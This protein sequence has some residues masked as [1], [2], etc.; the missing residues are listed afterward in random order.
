ME[1]PTAKTTDTKMLLPQLLSKHESKILLDWI[2]SLSRD[3]SSSR[4]NV[5]EDDLKR[6]A[7]EFLSALR[8]A[9][10]Q[11]GGADLQAAPWERT[12]AVLADISR[13]QADQGA[14]P[15]EV[16]SFIFSLK[17]TLFNLLQNEYAKTPEILSRE[18]L[19]ASTV[20]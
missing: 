14:T 16:A 13:E 5:R 2:S 19:N 4:G 6:Q 20:L 1:K 9:F 12:R 18:L 15:S 8:D 11:E 10:Q 7:K 3:R 17:G